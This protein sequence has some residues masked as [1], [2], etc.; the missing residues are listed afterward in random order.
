MFL[1][2]EKNARDFTTVYHC[3]RSE[4]D[5]PEMLE[6]PAESGRPGNYAPE[7]QASLWSESPPC[8]KNVK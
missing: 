8:L 6:S 4:G 3:W 7:S 5:G 1:Q 2:D